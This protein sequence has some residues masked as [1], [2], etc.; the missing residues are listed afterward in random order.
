MKHYILYPILLVLSVVSSTLTSFS[1]HLSKEIVAPKH[2][3]KNLSDSTLVQKDMIVEYQ[4]TA[5]G[6]TI[7]QYKHKPFDFGKINNLPPKLLYNENAEIMRSKSLDKGIRA[8]SPRPT[9]AINTA[10]AVGQ[11]PFTEDMTPSGGR[12]YTIPIKTAPN[13]SF[14]PQIAISYNSQSSNGIAGYGWNLSG[15]S[16]ISVVGK[17]IHYDGAVAPV[18]LS[19]PE[20]C[21]F[22]LDGVRLVRNEVSHKWYQYETAQGFILVEKNYSGMNVAYFKA[23][24]PN[25]NEATF[26]SPDNTTM[27]HIYPITELKDRNKQIINYEYIRSGNN[28]Y[29]SKIKYGK[30]NGDKWQAE[31][32]F[33]YVERDDF[34]TTYLSS[35]PISA[36]LLLKSIVSRN[37]VNGTMEE[38]CTY[39]LTHVMEKGVNQLTQ[40]DCSSGASSLNPLRFSYDYYQN[41]LSGTLVRES[42]QTI[43]QFFHSDQHNPLVLSR[44][45]FVKNQFSDGLISYPGKFS[46]Y[47]KIGEKVKKF[48]GIVTERYAIYGSNFPAGQDLL[49]APG[50]SFYS[51]TTTIKAE[52][53]FQTLQAVDVNG[54]GVDELVK[55]NFVDLVGDDTR[56]KVT[57]YSYADGKFTPQTCPY[58]PVKGVVNN[59]NETYSPMSRFYFF[60]DFM[61]TGKAQLLTISH[62]KAFTGQKMTSYFAL[63]NLDTKIKISETTLFSADLYDH[64]KILPLDMDG[65]GKLELCHATNTGMDVY[66]FVGKQFT[67]LYS[68]PTIKDTELKSEMSLGDLNGDGKIDI[69]VPPRESYYNTTNR[70][71]PVWAPK[72]CP[73]CKGYEPIEHRYYVECRHCK[74]DL[75]RFYLN[76]SFQPHEYQPVYS[77]CRKCDRMLDT[78]LDD[79]IPYSPSR[80]IEPNDPVEKRIT[81]K[82]PIHGDNTLI[83]VFLSY[84]DFGNKWQAFLSTGKGFIE[85]VM[86]IVNI[87]HGTQCVLMDINRD[88]NADL[89]LTHENQ[90]Y[91]HLN[92]NGII[93]SAVTDSIS[94]PSLTKILPANICNYYGT[95]HFI[96][97][98]N[99]N[100][101]CYRFTKDHSKEKLLTT[102]IDSY[103]NRYS[104]YYTDMTDPHGCYY[105]TNSTHTAYYHPF[106]APINLLTSNATYTANNRLVKSYDYSYHGAVIHRAGLGFSGFEKMMIRDE[107]EHATTEEVH[108]PELFGVTLMVKSPYKMISNSYT[109]D[110]FSS[111][112]N[113]PRLTSKFE[114]DILK[115]V[116]RRSDYQYDKFNNPV[117]E[118]ISYY[119]ST[120][121]TNIEYTYRLPKWPFL[122]IAGQLAQKKTVTTR[123]GMTWEQEENITYNSMD[124]PKSRITYIGGNKV[125]ESHWILDKNGNVT[126]KESAPYNV[127][128]FLRENSSYDDN[129]N[130]ILTKNV[131]GHLTKYADHDKNGNARTITDHKGRVTSRTFD[132]WG[133]LLS[134]KA[135][136]GTVET[137]KTDWGGEGLYTVTKS[138]TG[139]PTTI[140]HYDALGREIRTGVLRFDGQWQFVDKIY[141]SRGRLE[142]VSLPFKGASPK[143][144]NTYIYDEYNRPINFTEASGKITTWSYNK[145]S[146]TETKNGIATTKT[147]DETGALVKIEDPGGTIEYTLRPD[148]QP[149]KITAPGNVVTSFTYDQYGRKTSINDPSAGTQTL[150]DSYADNGTRTQTTT[151]ANGQTSTTISDQ[152]GRVTHVNSPEFN[153]VYTY[154]NYNL[155]TNETSTNGTSTAFTYDDFDR[156]ATV[157]KTIP[158]GKFLQK[159]FTYDNGKVASIQYASQSGN[160]A[161]ESFVYVN[162]HNTEIKLNNATT[163]WKLTEE[164]ELGQPTKAITGPIQRTY[165]FTE[166]GMPTDRTA[167]NIQNFSYQ[168]DVQTG[169]LISRTDRTRQLTETFGY[170]NLNRLNRMASQQIT[171][172]LNGNLTQMPGVGTM[173]YDNTAKPYQVTMLTP[174]GT[175]VP[176]REQQIG[177][178]SF[179][180]PDSIYENNIT[181][182]FTYNANSQ[183]VRMQVRTGTANTLTRYYIDN[184][185]ETDAE[186]NVERL[187]LDGDVYSAPAVYIKQ[188]GEWKIY[189]ICR[190][191]LG[192]ITHVANA[193]GTLKQELS[194]DAWGRLRDPETQVVYAV[195]TEPDLFLGRGYTGHEHLAWYGLINMNARLYDATLGRFLSPDPY[196][197]MPDCTQNFNRYSYCLNNPLKYNDETGEFFFFTILNAVKDFFV[198]TFGKVWTQGFNAWSNSSNWH[199]T[200][201]AF[202][203]DMGLFK[204]NFKQIISRFTWEYPQ[205]FLGHIAGSIQNTC[206]GVKSVSYYDGATAIEYYK[207]DWGAFTLGS[208]I[209][210][211]RGLQ[212]D[213]NNSLFQHEYGHY[214]QSQEMGWAY[215]PRVAIPSLMSA[216]K[217]DNKDDNNHDYQPFEQDANRRAFLYFNKHVKGFYKTEK[218]MH[219]NRGWDFYRNPLDVYHRGKRGTYYDY[220]NPEHRALLNNLSLHAR[221]YDHA[222]LIFAGAIPQTLVGVFNGIY[223][224]NHRVKEKK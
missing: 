25:G 156:V 83:E 87:H 213:P 105:P 159:T 96:T 45:K 52:E 89:L 147:I 224:N 78:F 27:Q 6:D 31:I 195:G 102:M 17:S 169:N 95:S 130:L 146:V 22:A 172:T 154:N 90:V 9:Q 34:T 177:Y 196:V 143:Y 217:D 199:S 35:L 180:R 173:A 29:L 3:I 212:A 122:Y 155:L 141:D 198:N 115:D 153:T 4:L 104:N 208:F 15:V 152:F 151:D 164:N 160:I 61:G 166:F 82:C 59:H 24:Y 11:I 37:M 108:D 103:G 50:L 121:R 192:S 13:A 120:H 158:D 92:E 175:A 210:G 188:N 142:K 182:R 123:E 204:G 47:T 41:N 91:V 183:R 8:T 64:Y 118:F 55:I 186:T 194:Y 73:L 216:K 85:S 2:T 117:K 72:I 40:I 157:R 129:N 12:T 165:G 214:L 137:V 23:A 106:I 113:N 86:P 185:Y 28:Y 168:F 58:F 1:Q 148:G 94:I 138:I 161:T 75:K 38:L 79:D 68:T 109:Q 181:T 209:N 218:D 56:L 70:L 162:G 81:F 53:G 65:D 170:D 80:F 19:N 197:Q 200:V 136:D 110:N 131:F 189:Y 39:T 51:E 126:E 18:D 57:I 49:I 167:G 206:Y 203:I 74:E 14:A 133:N 54:D 219:E 101:N 32:L 178:T 171:Y 128:K 84:S 150:S 163:V 140:T 179:Q 127:T 21:G 46:T 191:Y 176:A 100:V 42:T 36:N 174:T 33:S 66:G 48:L 62:D 139:K 132:T 124:F 149:S 202:K 114:T 220:Y 7:Y 98:E 77:K 221:W 97:V 205:T 26:G 88:G 60:G 20:E 119:N 223:Y 135:P 44:G 184:Q 5:E 190:D 107:I 71:L 43:A 16:M 125:N 116:L 93:Q 112:K 30:K 144:W 193:D 201:M 111:K 10:N 76:A 99:S 67:K 222:S 211:E 69:L 215:I 63:I 207:E 134:S 187:Y 145:L